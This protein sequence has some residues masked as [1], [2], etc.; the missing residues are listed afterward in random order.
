ML[1]WLRLRV[2]RWCLGPR[3]VRRPPRQGEWV[4]NGLRDKPEL[5]PWDS[6]E[7]HVVIEPRKPLTRFKRFLLWVL[8]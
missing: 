4:W 3:I 8:G 5:C 7:T 6:S 2:A 1:N